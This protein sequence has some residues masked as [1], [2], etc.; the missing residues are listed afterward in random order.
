MPGT[1]APYKRLCERYPEAAGEDY[2]FMPHYKNR[3]TAARVFSRQFNTLLE[4]TGL[5]HDAVLGTERTIYSLRHTAICMRIINSLGK[6]NIYTLAKNAGTGVE[7][8]ERFYARNLPLSAE[9]AKNLQSF[10]E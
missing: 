10:G 5:K 2:I 7:Q 3:A 4:R 6:V 8:I 1:I 9:L